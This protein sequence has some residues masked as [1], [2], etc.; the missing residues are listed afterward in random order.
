M[1]GKLRSITISKIPIRA[2]RPR[3]TRLQDDSYERAVRKPM[4]YA[5]ALAWL[6][7]MPHHKYA[8]TMLTRSSLCDNDIEGEAFMRDR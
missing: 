1:H 2:R 4:H 3:Y 6:L 8:L 5:A 7:A